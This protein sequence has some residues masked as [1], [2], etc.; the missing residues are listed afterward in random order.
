M[1]CI[2]AVC[3]ILTSLDLKLL[4][5]QLYAFLYLLCV[6][7]CACKTTLVPCIMNVLNNV[8]DITDISLISITDVQH[9]HF[10][11]CHFGIES[12]GENPR[13][14]H[15][16]WVQILVLSLLISEPQAIYLIM[17]YLLLSSEKNRID[18]TILMVIVS[19]K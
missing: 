9:G 5:R 8:I 15:L 2:R 13:L 3:V 4:E 10:L 6:C 1:C 17:L 16:V 19:L 12:N 18:Q 14:Q 11:V 7:V